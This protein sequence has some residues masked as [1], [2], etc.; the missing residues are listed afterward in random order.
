MKTYHLED[1]LEEVKEWYD[2][3]RFGD[4]DIYCPWD[5]INHVDQTLW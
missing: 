4:A 5:V 1:H 2:G 3:Y